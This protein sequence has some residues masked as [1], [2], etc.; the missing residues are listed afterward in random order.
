MALRAL[1]LF[2]GAGGASAGLHRAG[3]EVVGVDIRPQPHYPFEFVL[4]DALT[5]PL[6]GFDFAWASPLCKG[7]ANITATAKTKHLWPDQVTPI[8]ARFEA[9]GGPWIIENVVGAPLRNWVELCGS[10][11]GLKVYRHR[12][13]ESNL[14]LLVP[15]HVPHRDKTPSAGRG[16][17]PKGFI[18][19]AGHINN[20]EYVK[21]AMG[22]HWTSG[23]GLS[24]AIPP[25]YSEFLGRQVIE[26]LRRAA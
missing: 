11:F 16:I 24:Q 9:W 12:R 14:L 22:I 20:T 3:F 21:G 2:C 23:D 19:V 25:A 4:A 17:S 26:Q 5:Y 10:M 7:F 1:D 8:R 18:S 15:P 6:D 13:F